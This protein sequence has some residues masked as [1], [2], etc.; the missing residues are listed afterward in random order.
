MRL[1]F[2]LFAD[3][4][5]IFAPKGILTDYIEQRTSPDGTDL[6]PKLANLFE[7]LNTA[8]DKRQKTL[9]EDLKQFPYVNGDLFAERLPLPSFDSRMRSLLLDACDFDW[10]LIS[11]AIF[12]ALF[13][14]VMDKKKRR[15]IGAPY[16]SE[17]TIMKV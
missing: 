7:V 5:G 9:D 1:V 16:T 2:C 12:G 14:S 10:S 6:G 3:D 13:Q 15:A 4:T 8:E 17:Q 11:P